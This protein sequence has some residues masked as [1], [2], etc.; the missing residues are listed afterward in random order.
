MGKLRD[1][2]IPI[3]NIGN[4]D[5]SKEEIVMAC[6]QSDLNLYKVLFV[7]ANGLVKIVSGAEFE[8]RMKT[9]NATKLG[10]GD[11][12]VYAG[13][14]KD[15]KYAVL[16]TRNGYLLKF[17]LEQISEMKKQAAGVMGI[18]LSKEDSV[19]RAV[20][21]KEKEEKPL[22]HRD[23]EIDLNSVRTGVRNGRG[24]KRF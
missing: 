2:G 8:T 24:S 19:E 11:S 21:A 15:Q 16:M 6:S 14:I 13:V 20:L 18:K 3:D 22:L 12:L 23:T 9:I 10:E 5:S 1:K 7:T 4:Y 17:P